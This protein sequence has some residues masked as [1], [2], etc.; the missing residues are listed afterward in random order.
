MNI[1]SVA[2]SLKFMGGLTQ[3]KVNIVGVGW[4]GEHFL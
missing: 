2:Q 4:E 1:S 3:F